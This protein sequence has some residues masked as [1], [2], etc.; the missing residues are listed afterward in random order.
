[1]VKRAL[2]GLCL[3]AVSAAVPAAAATIT[4][5]AGGNLQAAI[6]AAQPG[7]T[8]SLQAGATFTG[9]FFLPAKGGT[10][11]I[12]IRSSTPDSQLPAPGTRITP[13]YAPLLAKIAS[14][15]GNAAI[16]TGAGS[17][18][19]R[20]QFLEF[21]PGSEASSITLIEFGAGDASQNTLASVPHHLILDRSYVHGDPG[22]GLRRGVA[23]NSG[24]AQIVGSYIADIKKVGKDTQ[25]IC[26][27][28]GPGPYLIE[29]NYLEAAGENIMFGGSDPSIPNLVPSN[30]TIRRNYITKPL[31]WM[32]ES[33]T[34][35][36]LVEFKNAQSV[37]VDGNTIENVWAAAQQG[38]AILLT[39]RN[40]EGTAPWSAVRNVTV[41]N[42]VIRHV[43]AAFNIS[44][45]DDLFPSQQTT[46]VVIRNNVIYDVSSSYATGGAMTSGRFVMMGN[47]PRDVTIDHNTVDSSGSSTMYIYGGKS[48]TGIQIPGLTITN[49]LMKRNY[50]GI[51]GD[52]V[53]EGNAAFTTYA[54]SVVMLRNTVAAGITSMYPTGN[55]F[56]ALTAWVDDFVNAAA[57]DYR[58]DSTSISRFAG[59]DGKDLGVNFTELNA[60]MAP[61]VTMPLPSTS[62]S[63]STPYSGT[64]VAL[65]GRVQFENYDVGGKEI[66]YHDTTGG[67]TGNVYR[68]NSVDIEATADSGGGYDVGWTMPGEWLKYTVNVTATATYTFDVRLAAKAA[69]GTFHIEVDGVNQT[70]SITVPNTGGWQVW[71]TISK[72]GV[73]LTSGTHV[74]RVVMDGLGAASGIANFN[75]FAIR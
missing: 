61:P 50:W 73:S 64:P 28:N 71:T 1:M 60:A 48:P 63:P 4:V 69:G 45:Y 9:S 58:L 30:I 56:P 43:G 14:A 32:S 12:T 47:G 21:L 37:V 55:F 42:N 41:Q 10:A 2:A 52:V 65:P 13:A 19:W 62:G 74:V 72:T 5:N 20:L 53:G 26:G 66:A 54:P 29:N 46:N 22:Y 44:G 15:S 57:A 18:Y 59:T 23:L 75:W 8:I 3:V 35:K 7:D 67:N 16:R 36:N 38:Y 51:N 33:W 49:N 70:G 17:N 24:E 39:P 11:Y 25:T 27:W 34:V 40:Q 31:K 6:D 68:A